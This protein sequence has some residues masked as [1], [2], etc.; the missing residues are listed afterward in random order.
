MKIYL[1]DIRPD[2]LPKMQEKEV[3][4]KL[5]WGWIITMFGADDDRVVFV[6]KDRNGWRETKQEAIEC[7][8]KRVEE[9]IERLK[10][11]LEN[12]I[13]QAQTLRDMK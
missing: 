10:K 7:A 8:K 13:T 12:N 9:N 11:A 1:V 6:S 5:E 4:Q 3:I 2:M